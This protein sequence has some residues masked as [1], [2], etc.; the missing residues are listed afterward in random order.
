MKK[1]KVTFNS[2]VILSFILI[3]LIVT[4]IGIITDGEIT[5]ILFVTYHSSLANPLTYI[6]FVTHVFG[7][8]GWSHFLSNATYIL[9]LGPM[10]EEKYGSRA[11]IVLMLTT[12]I[13]TGIINYVFFWNVGLCG[14]SGIVFAM[15]VLAS[16]T[17]F[18]DGEIPLTF[19]L[20]AVVYI[21]QQIYEG[22]TVQDDISNMAHIVGGI[23]GGLAGYKLNKRSRAK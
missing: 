7:H 10:L 4:I 3:C 17:G 16:F 12:A 15:I 18:N 13:V 6:R 5:Q 23:I 2:P 1:I 14:A 22:V 11:L 8:N 20:V 21:G 9:L 19:I